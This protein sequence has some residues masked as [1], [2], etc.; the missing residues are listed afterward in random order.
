MRVNL[1]TH[2]ADPSNTTKGMT[3]LSVTIRP[4]SGLPGYFQFPMDSAEVM[5]FIRKET[6]LPAPVLERFEGKLSG[7]L[8]A[9]LLGV[10]LSESVLTAIGYFID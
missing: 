1:I 9:K 6:R 8:G 5:R 2:P 4:A 7:P 10:E 3:P